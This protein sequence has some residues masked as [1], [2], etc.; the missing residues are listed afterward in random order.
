MILKHPLVNALLFALLIS[1]ACTW[2]LSRRVAA[3]SV[4]PHAADL[5]YVA[6]SRPLQAGEALKPENMELAPWPAANPIAGASTRIADLA[7]RVVLFPLEKGEPILDRELAAPGSA[8]GLA[9]KIPPGMRAIALRSDEV[10]GVAGFLTPGS[11]LDVLV[12]YHTD[13]HPETMTATVL[14]DA[15]V[16]AAGQQIEPDPNG[17]PA[18]VTVVTL[19]LTPEESERAFLASNQ[20]AIHFVLRNAGDQRREKID[21]VF[22]SQ[23]APGYADRG[24]AL[25]PPAP[26]PV[27]KSAPAAAKEMQIETILGD[28]GERKAP[29]TPDGGN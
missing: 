12:S 4:A 16:L 28:G 18:A 5:L 13:T 7:G 6:P 3:R 27:L 10:V 8:V 14:Q 29:A 21:P 11:H 24:S 2:L 23:L 26:N 25:A 15:V 1:G 17:K 22:L 20:G 19:L 9:A